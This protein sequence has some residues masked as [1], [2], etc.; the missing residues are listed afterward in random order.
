MLGLITKKKKV[1]SVNLVDGILNLYTELFYFLYFCMRLQYKAKVDASHQVRLL[2]IF[3][4]SM[5]VNLQSFFMDRQRELSKTV[6]K[7]FKE[8]DFC[9]CS[10]CDYQHED[11][12]FTKQATAQNVKTMAP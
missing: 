9:T 1:F 3:P 11:N 8:R 6:T 12:H 4:F 2:D 10:I 7:R 5:H